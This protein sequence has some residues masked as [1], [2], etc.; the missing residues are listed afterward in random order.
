M[1]AHKGVLPSV[2]LAQNVPVHAPVVGVPVAGLSSGFGR[3]VYAAA[4]ELVTE[5][6]LGTLTGMGSEAYRTV[7]A[8]RSVGAPEMTAAGVVSPG[9]LPS[10]TRMGTGE[11]ALCRDMSMRRHGGVFPLQCASRSP[12]VDDSIVIGRVSGLGLS[13]GL[14]SLDLSLGEMYRGRRL[15]G[16]SSR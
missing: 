16:R 15:S 9:S 7:R 1:P 14:G 11:K 6:R 5:R 8:W 13:A 4:N 10:M 3:A 12:V 2:S